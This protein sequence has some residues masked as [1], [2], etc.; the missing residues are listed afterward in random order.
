[1][2]ETKR[3]R[4]WQQW[5]AASASVTFHCK[6]VRHLG[7]PVFEMF[8]VRHVIVIGFCVLVQNVTQI[9]QTMVEL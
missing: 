9:D 1:M 8:D 6:P 2:I 7:L 4:P 5:T 3:H